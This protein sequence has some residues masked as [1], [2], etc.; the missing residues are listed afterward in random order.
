VLALRRTI[1]RAIALG[2]GGLTRAIDALLGL[3]QRTAQLLDC[4]GAGANAVTDRRVR[5]CAECTA[6]ANA[7]GLLID[8]DARIGRRQQGSA[9][10]A[11]SIV[12]RGI[13]PRPISFAEGIS[14]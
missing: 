13:C 1:S 5:L 12:A 11:Q 2:N 8:V 3:F 9:N 14:E 7:E 10:A 4:D 6:I